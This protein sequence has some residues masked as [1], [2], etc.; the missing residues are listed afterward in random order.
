VAFAQR[1]PGSHTNPAA[2]DYGDHQQNYPSSLR[3]F[4]YAFSAVAA[5]RY[6]ETAQ[7][8]KER[9]DPPILWRR[10]R[11]FARRFHRQK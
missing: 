5:F 8:P 10:L 7:Y 2:S 9:F 1:V 6:A 11:G 4:R 3:H